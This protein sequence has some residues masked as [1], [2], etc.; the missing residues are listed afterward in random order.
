MKK[1]LLLALT[2]L[3]GLSAIAQIRIPGEKYPDPLFNWK[4]RSDVTP[5]QTQTFNKGIHWAKGNSKVSVKSA[6]FDS[7]WANRFQTAL[8]SVMEATN[9]KGASVAV[10]SPEYGMWNGV[11][12]IS[13][14]GVPVTSDMR[15]GIGS[16]TK[17]FVAVTMV[18]L[19][20]EGLLTLDDHLYQWLPSF[21]YVDSSITIRQLLTHESGLFDYWNDSPSLITQAWPDTGRYWTSTEII[22]SIGPPHF[23]P[24]NGYSYSNTNYVLAGMIIE[25]ATGQ[26]WVQ[27]IHDVVFDP[28][29]LDSTF[30][31]AQEPRNGPCSAE[32][33]IFAGVC[34]T[35]VPMT[36]EYSQA[37]ACGAILA[38]ASEMVQWYNALFSGYILSDSSLQMVLSLDPSSMYGL[39]IGG[40]TLNQGFYSHSGGMFGFASLMV[41]DIQTQSIICLL[42]N[43]RDSDLGSKFTAMMNAF[44]GDYPKEPDDAGIA[45]IEIPADHNCNTILAPSLV[46]VNYGT[47]P[48]SSVTI[49]Y[50]V[51]E[52]ET[53]V[54]NWTGMLNAGESEYVILPNISAAI[55]QHSITAY[56]SLP[57]GEPEGHT[58]NDLA[59]KDFIT[60]SSDP[61]ISELFEYFEGETFPPEGWTVNPASIGQWGITHLTGLNGKG[62]LARNNYNDQFVGNIYDFELPLLNISGW[63]NTDFKFDYAYKMYPGVYGDSLQVFMSRDCGETWITLFNKG[64]WGLSTSTGTTYDMFYPDSPDDW[65]R[66]SIALSAFEGPMLIRFRAVNG[67]GNNLYIDN[68]NLDL[69]TGIESGKSTDYFTVYP[70]PFTSATTFAFKLSNSAQVTLEIYD[71]YGRLVAKPLNAC[72]L[73]GKQQVIWNPKDYPAGIYYCHLQVG[74]RLVSKK[75]IKV[76]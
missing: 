21:Q 39:G 15:F 8:D 34:V 36:A 69:L 35:N 32:W 74:D 31:G 55:G 46:L 49:N 72:L 51:D 76:Q 68:I 14:P 57:N 59:W 43:D 20:E 37:N 29:N 23:A 19:Q 47:N 22:E 73:T 3:I 58:F 54:F 11:S 38:T 60:E 28:M 13:V 41:Y 2:I 56:T 1:I 63:Y 64:A 24:G 25:A 17:L 7:T 5:G 9:A 26:T 67:Y 33:D 18:K 27:K 10:Y 50:A 12:G 66:V 45:R 30:I 53:S 62:T 70:N 71:S 61:Q 42:F 48:L 44:Y 6:T 4:Q 52:G 40:G 65:K 75:I 16:N